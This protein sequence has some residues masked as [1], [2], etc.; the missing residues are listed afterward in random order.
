MIIT[1]QGKMIFKIEEKMRNNGKF[2]K[3]LHKEFIYYVKMIIITY[4]G[5]EQTVIKIYKTNGD[6]MKWLNFC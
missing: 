1:Y 3:I 2:F 5:N 6:D 4:Y